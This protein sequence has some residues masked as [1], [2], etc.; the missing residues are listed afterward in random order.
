MPNSGVIAA[1]RSPALKMMGG[2]NAASRVLPGRKRRRFLM[3]AENGKAV[4]I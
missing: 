3:I 4:E 1:D 2:F